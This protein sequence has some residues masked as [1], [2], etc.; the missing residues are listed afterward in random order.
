MQ[1]TRK[2]ATWTAVAA[3]GVAGLFAAETTQANRP[4]HGH[5]RGQFMSQLN[6]TDAQKTQAKS[7]FQDARQSS[8]PVRQQL[9]ETRK[10]LRAA[11]K[12]NDT[13]QIQ[14]LSTVM[15]SEMGQLTA[16]RSSASAKVYQTLTPEQKQKA[17][18]LAQARR[19]RH[20]A[21]KPGVNN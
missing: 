11:V 9:M 8:Q 1:F 12:A 21:A 13:A 18:E 20:Q 15:G 19:A 5:G 17:D 7:I 6:L 16:I 14:Q 10:S 2:F 4:W 3:L